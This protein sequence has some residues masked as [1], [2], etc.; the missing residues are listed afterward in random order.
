MDKLQFDKKLSELIESV[1]KNTVPIIYPK[2]V[3]VI[4]GGSMRIPYMKRVLL[5]TFSNITQQQFPELNQT[6]NMD[7]S[8][9]KGACSYYLCSTIPI[10]W[11]YTIEPVVA[12]IYI[13]I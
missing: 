6:L 4:H 8:V 2:I 12:R 1:L 10:I 7:E 5:S 13:Y 9:S 3:P 11:D